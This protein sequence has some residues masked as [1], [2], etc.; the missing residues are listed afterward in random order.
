MSD[1]RSTQRSDADAELERELR[2][3][4]KFTLEEAVGRMVGPAG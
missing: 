2:E 3:E 1:S 4:R